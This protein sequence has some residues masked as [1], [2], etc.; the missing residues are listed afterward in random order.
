MQF[1][2]GSI[3]CWKSDKHTHGS[4]DEDDEDDDEQNV[5]ALLSFHDTVTEIKIYSSAFDGKA[6]LMHIS[7]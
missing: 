7:V 6:N 4:T 5:T 2:L 1:T 3:S